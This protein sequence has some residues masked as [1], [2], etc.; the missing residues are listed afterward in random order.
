MTKKMTTT[1]TC[2]ESDV[3]DDDPCDGDGGDDERT[4]HYRTPSCLER[5]NYVCSCYGYRHCRNCCCCCCCYCCCCCCSQQKSWQIHQKTKASCLL[6][7]S[8]YDDEEGQNAV[9][10]LVASM[11]GRQQQISDVADAL[12][13]RVVDVFNSAKK[14]ENHR[15][16]LCLGPLFV[17]CFKC[18]G[19]G[20]NRNRQFFYFGGRLVTSTI[21]TEMLTADGER[22]C[23]D[24]E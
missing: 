16:C 10:W 19:Q 20:R 24:L 18:Q 13:W 1:T 11:K 8:D 15:K 9:V 23:A 5:R 3:C 4:C 14:S 7:S 21:C 17:A 12:R 6:I 22:I 2:C